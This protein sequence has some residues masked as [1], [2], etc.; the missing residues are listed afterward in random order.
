MVCRTRWSFFAL[1]PEK[2]VG[3]EW[4]YLICIH[5]WIECF[6]LLSSIRGMLLSSVDVVPKREM[7]HLIMYFQNQPYAAERRRDRL[8]AEM[9]LMHTQKGIKS[10][11]NFF[12]VI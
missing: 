10:V 4:V 11:Q 8:K 9:N 7:I 2:G 5:F 6:T 3:V 1:N 12:R